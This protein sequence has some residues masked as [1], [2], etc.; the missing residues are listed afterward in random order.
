[1][2]SVEIYI[3]EGDEAL[4]EELLQFVK[5]SWEQIEEQVND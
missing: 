5:L 4:T 3:K 2:E 1:M